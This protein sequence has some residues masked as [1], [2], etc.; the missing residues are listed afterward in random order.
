MSI[1]STEPS[2]KTH[3]EQFFMQSLVLNWTVDQKARLHLVKAVCVI[4]GERDTQA[5]S[6][7][8]GEHEEKKKKKKQCSFLYIL[9]R[10]DFH[11][12]VKL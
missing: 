12:P 2:K 5:V 11:N 8:L 7:S 1:L 6:L 10:L 3:N 4:S 9:S